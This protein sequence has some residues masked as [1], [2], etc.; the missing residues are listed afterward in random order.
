MASPIIVGTTAIVAVPKN[1]HRNK[2]EFQN[3]GITTLY[4]KKQ[5]GI[6]PVVPTSTNYDFMI[7]P[8]VTATGEVNEAIRGTNSVNQFN[9]VSSASGGILAIFETVNIYKL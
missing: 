9:V 7:G 8:G 5:V 6:V 4:F 3:T 1:L 2:V